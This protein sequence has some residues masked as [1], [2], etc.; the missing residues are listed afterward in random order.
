MINAT[1]DSRDELLLTKALQ[2][3]DVDSL[4]ADGPRTDFLDRVQEIV[5]VQPVLF[6]GA[7]LGAPDTTPLQ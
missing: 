6:S 3:G 7:L 4:R 2:F 1:G 5:E